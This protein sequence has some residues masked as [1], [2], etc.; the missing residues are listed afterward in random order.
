MYTAP[1]PCPTHSSR[2]AYPDFEL[3]PPATA[4]AE[5]K[6]QGQGGP[7]RVGLVLTVYENK[8]NSV[9]TKAKMFSHF[10]ENKF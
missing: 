3:R 10:C 6:I 1:P 2:A 7:N 8:K 5:K 9:L 4:L